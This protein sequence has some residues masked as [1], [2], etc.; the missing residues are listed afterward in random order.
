MP[1]RQ[2]HFGMENPMERFI[3]L[4][5]DDVSFDHYGLMLNGTYKTHDWTYSSLHDHER[6]GLLL[7]LE[8]T[9]IFNLARRICLICLEI[10]CSATDLQRTKV[11]SEQQI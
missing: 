5:L 10:D 9:N 1:N 2:V 6:H 7:K 11:K 4:T 3:D 8:S